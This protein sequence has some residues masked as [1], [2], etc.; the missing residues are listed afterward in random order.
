MYPSLVTDEQK[1]YLISGKVQLIDNTAVYTK[2]KTLEIKEFKNE[3]RCCLCNS[4]DKNGKCS[5][6]HITVL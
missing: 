1:A 2:I 3:D 6:K 5:K 4:N